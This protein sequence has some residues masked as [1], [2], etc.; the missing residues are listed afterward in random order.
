MDINIPI[1]TNADADEDPQ[2]LRR[3]LVAL[4][5]PAVLEQASFELRVF[6]FPERRRRYQLTVELWGDDGPIEGPWALE[7]T[8]DREVPV[9]ARP[10]APGRRIPEPFTVRLRDEAIAFPAPGR[11][12]FRIFVNRA[13]VRTVYVDVALGNGRTI[14]DPQGRAWGVLTER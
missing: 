6:P 14:R 7:A 4:L 11:Y 5:F 3:D 1:F 12:E 8:V 13:H 9:P 10:A 2:F